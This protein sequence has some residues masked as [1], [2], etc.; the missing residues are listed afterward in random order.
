MTGEDHW[1]TFLDPRFALR[2]RYPTLTPQGH[3]THMRESVF[4]ETV[5]FHLSAEH[6]TEVYFEVS[7]LPQVL[8]QDSISLLIQDVETRLKAQVDPLYTMSFKGL[9][10]QVVNF[11]WDEIRRQTFFVV[12]DD[13]LYRIL[14]DPLSSLS[15]QIRDTL[16]FLLPDDAL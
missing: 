16:T 7:L 11:A 13:L 6:S 4:G 15:V 1:Q 14:Y 10:A 3:A 8:P 12:Y 9:E 5:R 2:F